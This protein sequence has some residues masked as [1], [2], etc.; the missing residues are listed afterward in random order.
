MQVV[1]TKTQTIITKRNNSMLFQDE[2]DLSKF[3]NNPSSNL[4]SSFRSHT[5]LYVNWLVGICCSPRNVAIY[6]EVTL[7]A[8]QL[9]SAN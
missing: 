6:E 2:E 5:I 3:N 8:W 1:N 9:V 4:I 7:S